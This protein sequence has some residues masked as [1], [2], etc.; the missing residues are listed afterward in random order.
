MLTHLSPI[1]YKRNMKANRR[2][3]ETGARQAKSI[4][5]M[6]RVHIAVPRKWLKAIE[7]AARQKNQGRSNFIANAAWVMAQNELDRDEVTND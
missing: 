5:P 1:K 2:P 4:G 6:D 3:P 7:K